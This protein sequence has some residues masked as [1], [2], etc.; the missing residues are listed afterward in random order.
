MCLAERALD[1]HIAK[2]IYRCS[3]I[4]DKRF[5][6]PRPQQNICLGKRSAHIVALVLV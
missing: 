1:R 6:F 3:D 2:M 5:K 4:S